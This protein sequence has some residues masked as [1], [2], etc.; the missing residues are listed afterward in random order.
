MLLAKV[1]LL[2]KVGNAA[3]HVYGCAAFSF[4]FLLA[5]VRPVHATSSGRCYQRLAVAPAKSQWSV[6]A[7]NPQ[8]SCWCWLQARLDE[9]QAALA[10]RQA[11]YARD[12]DSLTPE[13]EEEFEKAVEEVAFR[14]SILQKRLARHEETA[15]QQY[16][17]LDNRLRGDPR[18]SMLFRPA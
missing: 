12:R 9:E 18:L 8:H 10:R 7:S 16:H 3:Q 5:S 2:N 15:L 6:V 11:S 14:S 1:V 17:Q 4:S 13:E